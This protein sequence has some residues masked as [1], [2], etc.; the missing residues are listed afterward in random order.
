[1]KSGFFMAMVVAMLMAGAAC[2]SNAENKSADENATAATPGKDNIVG[3]WTLVKII[4]DNNGNHKIDAEEEAKAITTMQD[5]MK[6]NANGT[7][8][9]TIAKLEGKYEVVTKEDG[10]KKLVMYDGTG[11][12]TNKGRYILSVT[13]KELVINRILGGSDFEVF[14][15][16]N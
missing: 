12:E 4:A 9:Y 8:Q 2:Q 6:L 7:C 1:M 5:Y 15:R 13:D 3:E 11:G 16:S 14:K 10:R